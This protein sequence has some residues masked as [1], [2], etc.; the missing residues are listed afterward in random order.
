MIELLELLDF[1]CSKF[2][3]LLFLSFAAGHAASG[4]G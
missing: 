2:F 3:F 4:Y 1:A